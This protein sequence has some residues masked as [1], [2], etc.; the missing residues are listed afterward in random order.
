MSSKL[1]LTQRLELIRAHKSGEKVNDLCRKFGISRLL[2]YRLLKKYNSSSNKRVEQGILNA[3]ALAPTKSVGQLHRE[4]NPTLGIS[5]YTVRNVLLRNQL[6]KK[7]LRLRFSKDHKDLIRK[8]PSGLTP[9]DRM[10]MF[11]MVERGKTV[12][13]VCRRFGISRVIFYRLRK[14]YNEAGGNFAA[15]EDK[16]RQVERFA[17]QAPPEIEEKVK[18]IIVSRPELSSHRISTVLASEHQVALGNHGVHN[19]LKRLDLNTIDKRILFA[20]GSVVPAPAIRVAPL[21]QPTMPMYRL[22]MLLAP[23]VTV[24]KLVFRRPPVGILV[25]LL[26]FLPLTLVFLWL[27]S[28]VNVSSQ[29]SIVGLFFAS[30]ALT[31]GIFFFIYSLKYYLSVLL[32]LKLASRGSQTTDS[33]QLT[34]DPSANSG[35]ARINPLLVNLE[36]VEL[37]E[38]PFVSIH[39]AVYNEKRVVERLIQA[40]TAQEWY[41]ASSESKRLASSDNEASLNAERYTLNAKD[42]SA[43]YEVVIVDDSTDETTELARQTLIDNGWKLSNS[44]QLTLRLRSGQAVHS[45][46]N[47]A[48]REPITDNPTAE[49]F[50][51]SKPDL[52]TVKL[53]HR[54]SREGFKGGALQRALENTN[55]RAEYI[56]V[57]D[58][59]FVPFPDTVEQFIKTFQVLNANGS[60]LQ[61]NGDE[62][63]N[64]LISSNSFEGVENNRIRVNSRIAAVQP[65]DSAQ[66]QHLSNNIA[67]VQGY[68]WHVLNKSENWVTRG[69]RTEYAGSYV[70]ERAG[71][72]IYQGL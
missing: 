56:C 68:Q 17:R 31:F 35:Q 8:N 51:F 58:A 50:V 43:N 28:I 55:P 36:K 65:F 47:S 15:L 1:S 7:D 13:E 10:I 12:S 32:V 25:T 42:N 59:D 52:P 70:V 37:R 29:T 63:A 26:T 30:I 38:R 6:N 44:S 40:C 60:E 5:R 4:L 66:D 49:V 18:Q 21:Y 67:A 48:N 45:R 53:I 64:S 34:T 57:F 61:A 20:Q 24:P 23:F 16:K 71:E 41:Q 27:R 54:A 33:R 62:C 46:D 14:R 19:V 39:V 11:D 22:R 72:E 3:V 69:V 2:F 9:R